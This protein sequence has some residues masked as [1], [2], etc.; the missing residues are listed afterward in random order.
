[1]PGLRRAESK[2]TVRRRVSIAR[3]RAFCRCGRRWGRLKAC[4]L[5]RQT[6]TR[7]GAP[8]LI[9]QKGGICASGKRYSSCS[10]WP[11]K[12]IWRISGPAERALTHK[13]Y[14]PANPAAPLH[15]TQP[16]VQ[17]EPGGVYTSRPPARAL[18]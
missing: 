7:T 14:V 2:R 1:M 3:S 9:A 13:S 15:Q 4:L 6:G 18:R 8:A 5:Q 16:Y 11:G 17:E 10:G 12:K